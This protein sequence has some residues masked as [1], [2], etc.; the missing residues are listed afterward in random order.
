MKDAA[1]GIDE[2]QS[3]LVTLRRRLSLVSSAIA[4]CTTTA[5]LICTVIATLFLG[6]SMGFETGWLVSVLF[7]LAMLT[8]FLALVAFLREVMIA[9]ATVRIGIRVSDTPR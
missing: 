3:E 1:E 6:A 9:A 8:L 5:L 4:L 2:I 7:V